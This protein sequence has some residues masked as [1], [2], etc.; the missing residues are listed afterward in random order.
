MGN[1]RLFN[2]AVIR[3]SPMDGSEDV[4]NFLQ[5]L[6]TQ[7]TTLVAGGK[8]LWGALLSPQGK[9]LFDFLICPDRHAPADLLL[10]CEAEQAE[11]LVKRLSLYRLR[12]KIAIAVDK[13]LGVI[14]SK[15]GSG[16][17]DPRLPLLGQRWIAPTATD[18]VDVGTEYRHHRLSLGVTEGV[19]ELGEGTTLWLECNAAELNGVSFTK[20]CYIG[21]ENTARMNWRSKVNRRLVVVPIA[22]ADEKRQRIAYPEF[23]LS[24]EH[25]RV[26]D[27][28]GLDLPDWLKAALDPA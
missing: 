13:A 11:A 28:A 17:D 9:A 26:E 22:Q 25:R 19:A 6:V 27:L 16:K 1:P 8:S 18:D 2:R 24:V 4:R 7:D 5:G 12:K 15:D 21:Q 23:G 20:G 10:D 3:L 14:W